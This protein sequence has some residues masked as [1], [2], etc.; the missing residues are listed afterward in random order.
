MVSRFQGDPKMV[1]DENGSSL[2]IRGGQPIMDQGIE[3][4]AL[5]SL[6]TTKVKSEKIDWWGNSYARRVSQ[7]IGSA[8]EVEAKKTIT[9]SQLSKIRNA[10]ELALQWMIDVGA[11]LKVAGS[12]INPQSNRIEAAFGIEPPSQDLNIL[13]L[14][15][16]GAN[17]IAQKND[18]ANEKVD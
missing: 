16:Y 1:L 15:Q 4:A 8:F 3:N 2:V 12:V 11:A 13:L 18:P 9:I 14:K 7:K 6:F 5:I 17:W 10:G